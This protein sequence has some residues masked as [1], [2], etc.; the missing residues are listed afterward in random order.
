MGDN[1]I[2]EWARLVWGETA[3]SAYGYLHNLIIETV[4]KYQELSVLYGFIR[5]L[6]VRL[7]V[8]ENSYMMS[9]YFSLL[10][11]IVPRLPDVSEEN[12]DPTDDEAQKQTV[13]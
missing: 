1:G 4:K 8:K 13:N 10:H 12:M 3:V 9:R 6:L 2:K 11:R 5:C 7:H